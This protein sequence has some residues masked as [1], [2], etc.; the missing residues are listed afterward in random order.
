MTPIDTAQVT[1]F[2]SFFLQPWLESD[3]EPT[4]LCGTMAGVADYFSLII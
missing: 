2:I 1:S 3:V 4:A